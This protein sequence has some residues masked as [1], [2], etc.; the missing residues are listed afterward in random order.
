M[1]CLPTDEN[2]LAIVYKRAYTQ[3]MKFEWDSWKAES[4]LEKH[5]VRFAEAVSVLEDD[6]AMTVPDEH[7]DEPRLA[8]IGMDAQA[9]ILVVVYTWREDVIR[10]ISAR[11]ATGRERCQYEVKS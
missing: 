8:T 1:Y 11:K 6:M 10:I 2:S 9:R 4:N 3:N 5:G 7:A